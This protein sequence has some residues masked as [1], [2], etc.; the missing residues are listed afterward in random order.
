MFRR[1]GQYGDYGDH[2]THVYSCTQ[3][4]LTQ[5][6]TVDVPYTVY[7]HHESKYPAAICTH[8]LY[9][10]PPHTLQVEVTTSGMGASVGV[11]D[12]VN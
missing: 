9:T 11:G 10:L 4:T 8:M 3:R 5:P 2:L 12:N 1:E 7:I 6:S